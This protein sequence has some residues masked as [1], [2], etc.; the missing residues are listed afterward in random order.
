MSYE[1]GKFCEQM[2]EK[3]SGRQE[4]TRAGIL[5]ILRWGATNLKHLHQFMMLRIFALVPWHVRNG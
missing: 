5:V 2:R 3:N 1:F 4:S